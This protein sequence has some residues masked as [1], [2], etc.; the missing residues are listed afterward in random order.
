MYQPAV[1][2]HIASG[3]KFNMRGSNEEEIATIKRPFNY[4]TKPNA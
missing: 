4:L 2:S 1:L 3:E